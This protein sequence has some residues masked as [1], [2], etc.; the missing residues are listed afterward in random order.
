[1]PTSAPGIANESIGWS[2]KDMSE[3]KRCKR[4]ATTVLLLDPETTDPV[5]MVYVWDEH[6]DDAI[7]SYSATNVVECDSIWNHFDNESDC[8]W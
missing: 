4:T 3:P 6:C 7:R 5:A 2:T 1:M 8:D